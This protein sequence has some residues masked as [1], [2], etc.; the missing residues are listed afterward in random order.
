ML[1]TLSLKERKLDVHNS[2]AVVYL[3]TKT[4]TTK[5]D[6][7]NRNVLSSSIDFQFTVLACLRVE[8]SI[9]YHIKTKTVANYKNWK[10]H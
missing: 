6:Q 2:V 4:D 10:Q 9:K 5:M 3:K 1:D 8:N 7:T